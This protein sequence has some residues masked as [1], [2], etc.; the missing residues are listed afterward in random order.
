MIMRGLKLSVPP[1]FVLAALAVWGYL[2]TPD[3]TA[4]P[5]HFA[6]DGSVNRYGSRLEAFGA[7]PILALLIC[8]LFAL[9]PVIDPRGANLRR[10]P[11][12]V[13]VS[14]SGVLWLLAFV[15][16]VITLTATGWIAETGW[17]PRLVGMG[18]GILFILIGNALGK[19]RPNWFVGIRTP[20]T[21]SSDRSWD[22]T[23][24]WAGWLFVIAGLVSVI[25]MAVLPIEAG[26]IVLV[27]TTL[28][29]AFV[30]M[31]ISY[32]VWRADPL[33]ETYSADDASNDDGV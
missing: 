16:G 18:V 22:V 14:W 11:A 27:S 1:L 25:S 28:L 9:V 17:A 29:A 10:S 6:A 13:L 20:W 4:I 23:H 2:A 8:G 12:L 19:A 5:V 26:F 7:L 30:P 31:G 32:L 21:L 15:Q 3:G 24:R 33:R